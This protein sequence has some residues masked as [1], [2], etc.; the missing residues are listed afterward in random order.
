MTAM[1][2]YLAFLAAIA[3]RTIIVLVLVTAGLRL[4]GKRE[5]G[6][7]HLFDLMLILVLSN[8]VQNSMTESNGAI[9]VAFVAS[10]AILLLGWSA[11]KLFV[12]HPQLER[13]LMGVPTVLVL[14]G[15]F[16]RANL[17][18]EHIAEREVL[19][20]MR[21]QGIERVDDVRLAVLETDGTISVVPVEGARTE[22]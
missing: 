19:M 1:P 22:G 10:G 6:E 21:K 4:L 2:G 5:I 12:H 9:W 13:R 15:R 8:A 7:M 18:R 20:E 3:V 14:H 11:A 16:V 17:Q